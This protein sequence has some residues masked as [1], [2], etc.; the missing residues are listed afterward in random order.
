MEESLFLLLEQQQALS[1]TDSGM[2]LKIIKRETQWWL[3][4]TPVLN[5]SRWYT[6]AFYIQ[7]VFTRGHDL[8]EQGGNW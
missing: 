2:A 3:K 4:S 5:M 8:Q 6:E 1:G 7:I